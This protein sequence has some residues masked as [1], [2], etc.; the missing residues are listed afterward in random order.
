MASVP[1]GCQFPNKKNIFLV[2]SGGGSTY[3]NTWWLPFWKFVEAKP[4][5][6]KVFQCLFKKSINGI[7]VT[8]MYVDHSSC[9]LHK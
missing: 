6:L 7:I 5:F 4:D 3:I 8:N 1:L 9:V 2:Y